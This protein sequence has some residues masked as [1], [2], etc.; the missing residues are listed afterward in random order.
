MRTSTALP[1]LLAILVSLAACTQPA[2]KMKQEPVDARKLAEL[3][4]QLGIQYLQKADFE[5]ALDR[6]N[7][8]V[9]ADPSYVD[10]YSTLALL[11]ANLGQYEEAERNFEKALRLEPDNSSALN[12]YG[13]FLCQLKRYDEGQALFLR[14]LS[15]PIYRNPELAHNNAGICALNAGNL[16]QAEKSLRQALELNPTLAPTLYHMADLSFR[17]DRHLPARAYLQRYS[18]VAQHSASSLWL[19]IQIERVLGDR[20]AEAS[21]ALQLE[22]NF[23]D[24]AETGL[25][26]QSRTP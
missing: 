4:T 22:K 23:P 13:Q 12:N 1:L 21:Y 20:D 25:L 11:H 17:L 24:A 6:L 19:G 7:R 10:A 26:Q 5:I 15:N 14:A 9:Q 8:A 16:E 18:E 3:N 2:P